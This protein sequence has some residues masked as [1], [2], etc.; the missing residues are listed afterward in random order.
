MCN[1]GMVTV[2][3]PWNPET[4]VARAREPTK[5]LTIVASECQATLGTDCV[6]ES[7]V[8]GAAG[9]AVIVLEPYC[10]L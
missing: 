4:T 3:G 8:T 6:W 5:L 2:D 9:V 7:V 10:D 1:L